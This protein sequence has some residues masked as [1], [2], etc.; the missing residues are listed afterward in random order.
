MADVKPHLY[1]VVLRPV[2]TE[3][4]TMASQYG[5][6]VFEVALDADKALIKEA[7]ET[8]FKVEVTKVNTLVRKGKTKRF[9]GLP[10]RRSDVKHAIVTLK[11][12]VEF[13]PTSG[14]KV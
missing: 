10:G 2:I 3:K 11:N 6:Y 14:M 13:D 7:V 8:L 1:D 5:Q 4:S 9:K 12:A